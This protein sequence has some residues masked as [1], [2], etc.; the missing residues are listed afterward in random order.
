MDFHQLTCRVVSISVF[1]GELFTGL[2]AMAKQ[3]QFEDECEQS[4]FRR[5]VTLGTVKYEE[6]KK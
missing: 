6:D 5:L 2:P 3:M 1:E 4:K